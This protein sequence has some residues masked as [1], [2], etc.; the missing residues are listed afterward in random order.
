VGTRDEVARDE[1]RTRKGT[2]FDAKMIRWDSIPSSLASEKRWIPWRYEERDGK[3]TKVPLD[4]FGKRPHDVR[5]EGNWRDLRFV[6]GLVD[7][8]NQT[9][10]IGFVLGGG[11]AGVDLDNCL[12]PDGMHPEAAKIV[13]EL[14]SYT[15]RSPSGKGVKIIVKGDLNGSSG[16][17]TGNTPW[18]GEIEA[19]DQSRFFAISGQAKQ[20]PSP[21]PVD[22]D[23]KPIVSRFF[24]E[25][26]PE[27][28]HEYIH[29]GRHPESIRMLMYTFSNGEKARRLFAG[30]TSDY[31]DDDSRADLALCSMIAFA[32]GPDPDLIAATF[33]LSQLAKREKWI[34]RRDYRERT[35][36]EALS[37]MTD[38]YTWHDDETP[39]EEPDAD[40]RGW[41]I[42][43]IRSL[44]TEPMSPPEILGLFY[45]GQRHILSGEPDVGKTWLAL[46]AAAQE[47]IAG[48]PVLWINTDDMPYRELFERLESLGATDLSPEMFRYVQ[49]EIPAKDL[50]VRL[51]AD[52]DIRLAVFDSF[53]AALELDGRDPLSTNDV[54]AFWRKFATPLTRAGTAFV[55]IDHVTKSEDRNKRYSFGAERKL[56][57]TSVH[58]GMRTGQP[59]GRG[60]DE[61]Y[62]YIDTHKDRSG[63]LPRPSAGRFFMETVV[64]QINCRIEPPSEDEAHGE[65]TVLM[66]RVSQTLAAHAPNA[67]SQNQIEKLTKGKA[68]Y[69]RDALELLVE[70]GHVAR[71]PKGA[72]GVAYTHVFSYPMDTE[73]DW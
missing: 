29:T 61:G 2:R 26:K 35:I 60:T 48:N 20:S 68:T 73:A 17:R 43:D 62:A 36:N 39:G 13:E 16:R 23:L 40:V 54:Q 64:N 9:L 53:N 67:L 32:A 72:S 69:I 14:N 7:G 49:P 4:A 30:D 19:Y 1:V 44:A 47:L 8:S 56:S 15:E 42:L 33:E 50:D 25:D 11:Y 58:I 59:F 10:G 46:Y 63:F 57:G 52:S 24:G 18:G 31:G 5:D 71:K 37:G 66:E 28:E 34:T 12:G 6:R 27:A 38:F 65:P 21:E 41:K 70:R 45:L 51:L 55:A 3:P 22:A